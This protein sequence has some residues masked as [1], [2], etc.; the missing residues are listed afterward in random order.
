M[1]RSIVIVDDHEA[2]RIFARRLLEAGGLEVTGEAGDG[3]TAV[4]LVARIAPD[5]VLLDI[6]L[7][8]IDGFEVARR[9]SVAGSP[10]RV[11]FTSTRDVDDYGGRVNASEAFIPKA[12]LSVSA[13]LD[14]LGAA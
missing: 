14:L 9:L 6:Q 10:T 1:A 8:D 7:P 3:A 12:D 4:E 2:F 11:L 13:V 5:A